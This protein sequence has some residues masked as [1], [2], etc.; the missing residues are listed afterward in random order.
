M[1]NTH[2]KGGRL[3]RPYIGSLDLPDLQLK[4]SGQHNPVTPFF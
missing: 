3:R 1:I 2:D 4:P